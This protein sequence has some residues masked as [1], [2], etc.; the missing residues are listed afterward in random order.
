M[1]QQ[2]NTDLLKEYIKTLIAS[3][4][5]FPGILPRQWGREFSRMELHTIYFTLAFVVR[6]ADPVRHEL[7]LTEFMRIGESDHNV[8]WFLCEFWRDLTP[9]LSQYPSMHYPISPES[10][11]KLMR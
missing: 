8:H 2:T 3:E 10:Q 6:T 7:L 4:V 5:V 1:Y 11:Q 9:L